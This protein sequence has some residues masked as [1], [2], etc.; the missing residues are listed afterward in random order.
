M[1]I[2]RIPC[3]SFRWNTRLE[4]VFRFSCFGSLVVQ[5]VAGSEFFSSNS[6]IYSPYSCF[7]SEL[8]PSQLNLKNNSNTGVHWRD[9][10]RFSRLSGIRRKYWNRASLITSSP[11]SCRTLSET[12]DLDRSSS[13]SLVQFQV[14]DSFLCK[15]SQHW[16][17]AH[18]S[19][20]AAE[21]VTK[22]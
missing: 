1:L 17:P 19:S 14:M 2:L 15:L 9:I 7:L 6:S 5:P 22:D 13:L 8:I 16:D 3:L 18:P 4:L 20:E 21:Y 11:L 10:Q 12:L